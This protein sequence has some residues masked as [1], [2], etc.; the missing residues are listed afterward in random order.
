MDKHLLG[1]YGEILAS[2][3]LRY[4]GYE[5][6]TAHFNC[7]L[8]EIDLI[9]EDKK[10]ICFV[11]VKTRKNKNYGY[12]ADFIF[13]SKIDK[14]ILGAR[15]YMARHNVTSAVRFDI[16]EVYGKILYSGF[17][18]DEINHIKNAFDV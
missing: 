13:K 4:H 8:G 1:A 6:I 17:S 18:V 3:Y 12:G 11:E 2:R 14:M 10:H 7:R 15:S 16:I 9:V 5:L